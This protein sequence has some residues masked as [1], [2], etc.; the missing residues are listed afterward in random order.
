MSEDCKQCGTIMWLLDSEGL[1][2][3]CNSLGFDEEGEPVYEDD[4]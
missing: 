1:C 4:A 2:P 3:V